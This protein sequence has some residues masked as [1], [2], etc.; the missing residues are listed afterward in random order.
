MLYFGVLTVGIDSFTHVTL[1][2]IRA[3]SAFK[4]LAFPAQN[5]KIQAGPAETVDRFSHSSGG[6]SCILTSSGCA[7]IC[8]QREVLLCFEECGSLLITSQLSSGRSWCQNGQEGADSSVYHTLVFP[9]QLPLAV[10]N[11]QTIAGLQVNAQPCQQGLP[12]TFGRTYSKAMPS[13]SGFSIAATVPSFF[14]AKGVF[15]VYSTERLMHIRGTAA[16]VSYIQ[17]ESLPQDAI[18]VSVME[19]YDTKDQ[20]QRM[21]V[22]SVSYNMFLERRLEGDCSGLASQIKIRKKNLDVLKTLSATESTTEHHAV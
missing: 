17:D 19:R 2:F 6:S 18:A 13:S 16:L 9:R 11:T 3:T 7:F 20:R 21:D 14:F 12:N 5:E 15:S 4:L 22:A 8:R 1:I 10:M